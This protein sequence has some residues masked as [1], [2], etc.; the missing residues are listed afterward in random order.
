MTANRRIALNIVATYGRSLYALVIGLFCGRWA[1]MALGD[2]DYGLYGVVGGLT[3]FIGFFNGILSSSISRFYAY[4]VGL[5]Q[6][7]GEA[8]LGL[9]E[10][11]RWFS[12][13]LT[14]HTVVP[15]VFMAAGYPMGV[16]AIEHWLTIPADR[17]HDC[18]WVFRYVCITCFLGM[19]SV[20]FNAMYGAKQLIAELT[21]Y[22]FVTSTLNVVVLYYMITHP[23]VW[24]SR[25]ALWSCVLSIVPSLIISSRALICFPECRIRRRHLWNLADMR[26]LMSFAGWNIFGATGNLLKSAGMSIL[27][28]K[29]F[30]P[31]QNAA[32]SIANTVAGQSQSL[33]GSMVGAFMPAITNACG[34]GDR[35]R[36]VMLVHQTCKFGALFVLPFALPLVLEI[37]EVMKLWLKTPPAQSGVL[38][39]WMMVILALEKMTTGHWV[40]VAANGKIACY[41]FIVGML[42]ILTL[43]LAWLMMWL[44]I[45]LYSVGYAL[46]TTLSL[47]VVVRVVAVKILLDISPRYWMLRIF[48]PLLIVCAVASAIGYLP[49]FFMAESFSRL[50][51]T[52]FLVEI[53][54][55]SLAWRILLDAAEREF[56]KSKV[57][58]V[59]VKI[60]GGI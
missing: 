34:A 56:L 35:K 49:R 25:Y 15:V 54:L 21:I 4:S 44:G 9:D 18:I 48:L 58:L 59:R 24:L 53:A 14:V 47:V 22:S 60:R 40:V 41:Q 16:Y 42:F 36:M 26:E 3:A 50:C 43:P 13:A 51:V 33:A 10:C 23:G 32:V 45:G 46:F 31:V 8:E 20:P 29:F 28:N 30:G 11:R 39:I 19:T 2:V 7:R 12:V 5:S 57:A 52:T 55:I 38:C 37:D 6:K 1:L 27:V 17:V